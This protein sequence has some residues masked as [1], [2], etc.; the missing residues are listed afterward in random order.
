MTSYMYDGSANIHVESMKFATRIVPSS[1]ELPS[2]AIDQPKAVARLQA[3]TKF[4]QSSA[5]KLVWRLLV[6]IP[7]DFE[8]DGLVPEQIE[9][10]R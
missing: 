9:C 10:T 3:P 1:A 4:V 7:V 8:G 5:P 6:I 2:P